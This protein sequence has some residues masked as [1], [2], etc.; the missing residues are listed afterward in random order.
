MPKGYWIARVDVRDPEGYK[1]YVAAAKQAFERFGAKMLARGG[2]CEIAE[3]Q[4]R[5]R[6]V[7]IEFESLKA[8]QDCYHSPEYQAARAIRLR[9]AEGEI[10]LVEGV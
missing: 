10:V 7:V 6:N 2:A 8:A 4:G 5:A 9:H 1:D 3:G